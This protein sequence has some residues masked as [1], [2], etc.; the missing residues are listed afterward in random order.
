METAEKLR[1]L[2]HG[3]LQHRLR[4]LLVLLVR[5][6]ISPN[7][8]TLVGLLLTL[9]AAALLIGGQ[10]RWAGAIFLLASALD[11]VDGAL[12]RL[13]NYATVFGAFLDSTLDR[14]SEGVILMAIAY[15]FAQ[16]GDALT[17]A[18]VVL[19]FLGG[20]LTSYTRARAEGLGIAC[21]GGWI[22]RVERVILIGAGLL[23]Q[24]LAPVIYLLALLTLWTAGQRIY[25]VYKAVEPH[26]PPHGHSRPHRFTDGR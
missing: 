1:A 24:I 18:A 16:Q 21:A 15:T 9:L 25:H 19:A 14:V 10:P 23:L 20:V 13:S 22:S 7:Q 26:G 4:P 8:V 5:L 12:A 17:V 6:R 2:A 3:H 11:L